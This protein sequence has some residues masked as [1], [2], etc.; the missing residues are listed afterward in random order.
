MDST[1]KAGALAVTWT[2]GWLL[3]LQMLLL[4]E[5]GSAAGMGRRG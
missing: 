5:G 4:R 1:G 2:M 3:L